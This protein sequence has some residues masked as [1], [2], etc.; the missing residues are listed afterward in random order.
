[1]VVRDQSV[2]P[3]EDDLRRDIAD[4]SDE[5]DRLSAELRATEPVITAARRVCK[6]PAVAGSAFAD[7]LIDLDAAVTAFDSGA[8]AA[9]ALCNCQCPTVW[10]PA[11]DK[12]SC[13]VTSLASAAA[14]VARQAA[15]D[16]DQE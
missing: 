8:S 13:P 4:L 14:V 2:R 11:G 5:I 16:N 7:A 6:A 9:D 3:S 1:M 12:P 10:H 15:C